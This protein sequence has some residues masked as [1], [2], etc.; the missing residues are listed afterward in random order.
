MELI[1][2][3]LPFSALP[4]PSHVLCMPC[5]EGRFVSCRSQVH[6]M[7]GFRPCCNDPPR[8]TIS[9]IGATGYRRQS[10]WRPDET[11]KTCRKEIAQ[12]RHPIDACPKGKANDV[13]QIDPDWSHRNR[14][15]RMRRRPGHRRLAIRASF[16]LNGRG[17]STFERR[18]SSPSGRDHVA[19][20]RRCNGRCHRSRHG[21]A[22]DPRL[23]QAGTR[24]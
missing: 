6:F 22:H 1:S 17:A 2:L 15:V 18:H 12:C 24:Q 20:R 5:H 8:D 13:T 3:G 23:V 19:C 9:G 7:Q 10:R 14:F 16:G 4:R 11:Q 21:L